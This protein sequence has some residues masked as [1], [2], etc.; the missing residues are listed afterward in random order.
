MRQRYRV[1]AAVVLSRPIA[2][3]MKDGAESVWVTGYFQN[4]GVTAASP[5]SLTA[6]V[7]SAIGDGTV[8]WSE[9]EVESISDSRVHELVGGNETEN[10]KALDG[11]VEGVWFSGGRAFY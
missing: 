11:E 5:E 7:E 8:D 10:Y 1:L 2:A 4:L 9:S 6:L 3:E